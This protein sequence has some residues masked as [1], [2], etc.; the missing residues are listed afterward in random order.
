MS[1]SQQPSHH[2]ARPG[3]E[4]AARL[5]AS[6]APL[7]HRE[8]IRAAVAQVRALPPAEVP[9]LLTELADPDRHVPDTRAT[10]LICARAVPC[11]PAHGDLL[12]G[13]LVAGLTDP[14][15]A[16]RAQAL[17]ALRT[18]RI[19]PASEA[20]MTDRVTAAAREQLVTALHCTPA[21][22]PDALIDSVR[23]T[24]GDREAARLLPACSPT[25]VRRL[26]PDLRHALHSWLPLARRVPEVVYETV[27]REAEAQAPAAREFW[28]LLEARDPLAAL[29]QV[30]PG[31]T[32]DLFDRVGPERLPAGLVPHLPAF[33]AHR[34]RL[35]ARLW[36]RGRLVLAERT[37][38]VNGARRFADAVPE[39]E[40]VAAVRAAAVPA[41]VL[42][43]L[44]PALPPGRRGAVLDAV[45]AEEGSASAT[46]AGP[47]TAVLPPALMRPLPARDAAPFARQAIDRARAR[48]AAPIELLELRAFL[49]YG[50]EAAALRAD[51]RRADSTERAAA[52]QAL[53]HAAAR[54]RRAEATTEVLTELARLRSEQDPVRQAAVGALGALPTHTFTAAAAPAL[55]RIASDALAARDLSY[56]T[57]LALTHLAGRLLH[58]TGDGTNSANR[59]HGMHGMRGTHPAPEPSA[60]DRAALPALAAWAVRTLTR[61]DGPDVPGGGFGTFVT[62]ALRPAPP[63]AAARALLDAVRPVVTESLGSGD[64]VPAL[65][66]A[67]SLSSEPGWERAEPWLAEII[68]RI[69]LTGARGPAE[70]ACVLWLAS[71]GP[72]A[73]R[74][75]A[76][77]AADPSAVVLPRVVELVARQADDLLPALASTPLDSPPYGRFHD[78]AQAVGGSLRRV[79]PPVRG[80]AH[81][82]TDAACAAV[83]DWL[84]AGLRDRADPDRS[85]GDELL[86]ELAA[87]PGGGGL[88]AVR[89]A[90]GSAHVPTA[91]AALAAL[92]GAER[93]GLVLPDLL[94][95][96]DGDRARVAV[97]GI[98]RVCAHV[99]PLELAARFRP[100]LER[101]TGTKV[102]ARKEI[103]R[104]AADRLPAALAGELLVAAFSA[105]GQHRDVRAAAV[106][107]AARL[108]TLGPVEACLRTTAREGSRAEREA[109]LRVEPL[110][111]PAA[112]REPYG[113]LVAEVCRRFLTQAPTHTDSPAGAG[114]APA[115]APDRP[116]DAAPGRA[117]DGAP[118]ARTVAEACRVLHR[119]AL[120]VPS[121]VDAGLLPRLAVEPQSHGVVWRAAV[122]AVVDA[123]RVDPDA[124]GPALGAV[125]AALL[126]RYVREAGADDRA[127]RLGARAEPAER[128]PRDAL[129]R[130]AAL[131]GSLER[132]AGQGLPGACRPVWQE[133]IALIAEQ[134]ASLRWAVAA[135]TALW[136]PSAPASE[137]ARELRAQARAVRDRPLLAARTAVALARRS[138]R[139]SPAALAEA[140]DAAL[141]IGAS[142]TTWFARRRSGTLPPRDGLFAG[143]YAVGLA[144]DHAGRAA[145]TGSELGPALRVLRDLLAHPVPE[146]RDAADAALTTW[147][148]KR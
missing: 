23:A 120:V 33:V 63:A 134:D 24:W 79:L 61:A 66:L 36:G 60:A 16:V 147:E 69:A 110:A 8:R 4:A 51:T 139:V 146:V 82:W 56:G 34:P 54:A 35:A 109:L 20:L 125:T 103:V 45:R 7:A 89:E 52:W 140:R 76:L 144:E 113:K 64:P 40:L 118:D 72:R 31:A 11:D 5:L 49:P 127:R 87:V 25:T 88:P 6:L 114:P 75:R 1:T 14:H 55:E 28:W 112:A 135:R 107:R 81:R 74:V 97:Y 44:L 2:S 29:A 92:P 138:P 91:E 137:R 21:A 98:G 131:A 13:L 70:R 85:P 9:D 104:L 80:Y 148:R 37:L 57:L 71:A 108:V 59:T 46:P 43:E 101:A 42:A 145:S 115:E 19:R 143:L 116:S 105:P 39:D 136:D 26:L 122:E 77:L 133:A 83:T 68:E 129:H 50:D 106:T 15:G 90:A 130:I 142:G 30:D 73:E 62:R 95:R 94:A 3:R 17:V 48:G 10:A 86:R 12:A 67:E 32:L 100:V 124:Y 41:P 123:A 53:V 126:G 117:S 22:L 27:V 78:P 128:D 102:T 93:P 84:A 141:A 38:S 99:P 47:E 65:S 58:T 18:G 132:T 111:L 96:A 121:A 119:W